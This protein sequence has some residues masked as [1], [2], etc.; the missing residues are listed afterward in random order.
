[1][2]NAAL[3]Q[4]AGPPSSRRKRATVAC[5]KCHSRKVRCNISTKGFPCAN[6]E[7]DGASCTIFRPKRTRIGIG[8][9]PTSRTT[10]AESSSSPL[11]QMSSLQS[12]MLGNVSLAAQNQPLVSP[13]ESHGRSIGCHPGQVIPSPMPTQ[14]DVD[15]GSPDDLVN[16][17][18][19]N[20]SLE[21]QDVQDAVP[22]Y[23]GNEQGLELMLDICR[24][25]RLERNHFVV[26][27]TAAKSTRPEDMSYLQNNGVFDLPPE[28]LRCELLWHYVHYIHPMVPIV[29]LNNLLLD[30]AAGGPVKTSPLLLWSMFYVSARTLPLPLVKVAGFRSNK[31]MQHSLY[32]KAKCLYDMDF[33]KNKITL[34]QSLI[35]MSNRY[36]DT[37]DRTGPWH[38]IGVAISLGHTIGLHRNPCLGNS[39]GPQ[40]S[41]FEAQMSLWKR[42]WWSCFHRETW[43]ALS[44]GRPMR[45]HP[46]DCDM[47]MPAAEDM[48]A[49]TSLLPDDIRQKYIPGP[50][51]C[52]AFSQVHLI[53]LGLSITLSKLLRAHYRPGKSPSIQQINTDDA[54]IQ[55]HAQPCREYCE[56][57]N[58]LVQN[59]ASHI[60]IH[61]EVLM[62]ILYRP[63]L[64]KLPSCN[65]TMNLEDWQALALKK[66]KLAADNI[67]TTLNRLTALELINLFD[68]TI[69]LALKPAMQIYLFLSTST[70]TFYQ[71]HAFLQLEFYMLV[72]RE[73]LPSA[74]TARMTIDL[75]R[76]AM[77][78]LAARR[79]QATQ[80][81]GDSGFLPENP[82]TSTA[83]ENFAMRGNWPPLPWQT[84]DDYMM[85][86]M[87]DLSIPN[88]GE[89]WDFALETVLDETFESIN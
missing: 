11:P 56:H 19:F 31:E 59:Y 89:S 53:N 39:T 61:Y 58:P 28:N 35:L 8:L 47:P 13:P 66:A 52:A 69:I 36:A 63:Y 78:K 37:E 1:M 16:P 55:E 21:G 70:N 82:S 9:S 49:G 68:S 30:C 75:F 88:L 46:E 79:G 5:E 45:I 77:G 41:Y 22:F 4:A 18:S 80:Q 25:E 62:I 10:H 20:V 24:P 40:Q 57:S 85:D 67:S 33:E 44:H 29:D 17:G 26:P 54:M 71:R 48:W 76:K 72:L 2:R 83:D 87:T 50:E 81:Y 60:L 86:N 84:P 14:T 32:K 15:D 7:Q 65:G 73:L 64:L 34:L 3:G 23:V 27:Y 42:L 38:W 43:L 51:D 6:C 74:W 12:S